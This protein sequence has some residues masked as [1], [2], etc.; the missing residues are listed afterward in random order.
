MRR[1]HS[2]SPLDRSAG[3]DSLN[4]LQQ[5]ST[6]WGNRGKTNVA[7]FLTDSENED[8][9]NS[10]SQRK[11]NNFSSSKSSKNSTNEELN[12]SRKR[13]MIQFLIDLLGVYQHELNLF[14][15]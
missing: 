9:V 15:T 6:S 8:V 5:N 11:K 1:A 3:R 10:P 13:G 14:D 12:D 7:D 4:K 2:V